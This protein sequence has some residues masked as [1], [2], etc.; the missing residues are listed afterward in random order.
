MHSDD[1]GANEFKGTTAVTA[2]RYSL[3]L[4]RMLLQAATIGSLRRGTEYG[5]RP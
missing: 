3:T 4:A 5:Y 1:V 2:V